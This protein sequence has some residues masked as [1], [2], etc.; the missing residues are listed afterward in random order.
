MIRSMTGILDRSV[1]FLKNGSMTE[2]DA[3]VPRLR[4]QREV[5]ERDPA[6]IAV[7]T[8][9]GIVVISVGALMKYFPDGPF[10]KQPEPPKAKAPVDPGATNDKVPLPNLRREEDLKPKDTQLKNAT[11][12]RTVDS[13]TIE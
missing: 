7:L 12:E 8:A 10:G 5:Y 13:A 1:L 4:R 6:L 11:A 9:I 2:N 3:S